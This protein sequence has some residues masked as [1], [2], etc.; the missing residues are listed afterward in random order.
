VA[1]QIPVGQL[2]AQANQQ[3]RSSQQQLE[4]DLAALERY[5]QDVNL[6]N[7]RVLAA[8]KTAS[9]KDLGS[10]R[11]SWSKWWSTLVAT[12]SAAPVPPRESEGQNGAAATESNARADVPSFA[13]GTQIWT[14]MGLRP[15]EDLRA[16]D[17]VLTQDTATGALGFSPVLTTRPVLREPVKSITIG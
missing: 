4:E 11:G 6:L 12:S 2:M 17:K 8:L 1:A 16:G 9:G 14:V 5:N 7:I 10:D 3:A 13:A 15:I